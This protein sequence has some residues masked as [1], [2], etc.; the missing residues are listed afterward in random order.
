MIGLRQSIAY[1]IETRTRFRSLDGVHRSLPRL[2]TT[3][4][5]KGRLLVRRIMKSATCP[6]GWMDN[7]T[8]ALALKAP[9]PRTLAGM[10]MSLATRLQF[11]HNRSDSASGFV[12]AMGSE[13]R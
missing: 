8:S 6:A 2:R 4:I 12:K 3:S 13:Y 5:A 7:S 1:V 9:R 11:G 10:D